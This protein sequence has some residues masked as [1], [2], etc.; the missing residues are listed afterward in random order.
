MA[1]TNER[2]R[3]SVFETDS[4]RFFL[5]ESDVRT[6]RLTCC[7]RVS[8]VG[9]TGLGPVGSET[10]V[11]SVRVHS[12]SVSL[13]FGGRKESRHDMRRALQLTFH[14]HCSTQVLTLFKRQ[15]RRTRV[16]PPTPAKA[17][18]RTTSSR[19]P[20]RGVTFAVAS[21]VQEPRGSG[22]RFRWKQFPRSRDIDC[23]CGQ[24]AAQH[25][26]SSTPVTQIRTKYNSQL[27]ARAAAASNYFPRDFR[28]LCFACVVPST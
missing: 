1:A 26:S 18:H 8:G 28:N 22:W 20:I 10:A 14:G 7:S 6:W 4:G 13:L 2:G 3:L 17:H 27:T 25:H 11:S 12:S 24:K 15:R 23:Q 21:M 9:P 16:T 5:S 19:R